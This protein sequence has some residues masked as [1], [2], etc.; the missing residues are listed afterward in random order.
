MELF[1]FI[2]TSIKYINGS[3]KYINVTVFLITFLVGLLYIY[4]FDYNRRVIV[5][6]TKHNIDKIE[7]KDEAENCFGYKIKEVSCPSDK[8]KIETLP[9]N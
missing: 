3:T 6:P 5:Y 2:N 4:Y 9:L 8:S 7:Y 1:K